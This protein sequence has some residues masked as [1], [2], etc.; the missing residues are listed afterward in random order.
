[1]D[2]KNY[3]SLIIAGI[4]GGSGKTTITLG[5]IGAFSR[6]L[7]V[8]PFKKGPDYIDAGWM[9]KAAGWPCYNLDP[10]LISEER[11][12]ASFINHFKGDIAIIEG[13][14]GLYDGMDLQGSYSTA[15]LS[16]LINV[17]VILVIDCSKITRTAS[18]LV[19]GCQKFD[20]TV[21]IRGVILNQVSSLRHE[22]I[23]RESIEHY[24]KI[25]VLG[26]MPRLDE[27]EMAERHMGLVP[28]YEHTNH[29]EIITHLTEKALQHIDISSL[30]NIAIANAPNHYLSNSYIAKIRKPLN[31]LK[32]GV[33]MDRAFQF[34]Y[35]ENIDTLTDEGAEVVYINAM[36]DKKLP[37][38]HGL[39]IGGGFPETNAIRLAKN[40]SFKSSLKSAIQKGLPVYAECGGLM[41]LGNK[42]V[43]DGQSYNMTGIYDI[44]F[45]MNKKPVAHGYTE[46]LVS[47]ENPFYPI[48][49]ILKGHEF[50]YSSVQGELSDL[51][52]AFSMKRGKGII[53]KRD[54]IVYK[55]CLATYTHV[56]ALGTDAWV[57]GIL[58][59]AREYKNGC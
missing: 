5:V 4:R 45:E 44:V 52:F 31:N 49:T 21:K 1:M 43:V 57:K 7:K 32:I 8:T 37:E 39:Y 30:N 46:A 16:K 33:I 17:P 24:C 10:Y 19:L 27:K 9:S 3:P 6:K 53:E 36:F 56:H 51:T 47:R 34:Y 59:T 55:N 54:G 41:Y 58:K 50:H 42:L 2:S 40:E 15:Q 12:K 38:I 48:G 23:I 35:P 22:N 13:N 20:E 29:D 11:V 14:R 26:A 25:P 18:A 28:I